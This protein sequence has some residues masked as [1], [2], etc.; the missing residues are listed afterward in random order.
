MSKETLFPLIISNT[1]MSL[2][3]QC[4]LRWF[5][6]RCQSL[7]KPGLKNI[8]LDAGAAFAKG[9]EVTREAF[10]QDKLT[11]AESIDQG[12]HKVLEVMYE[13]GNVNDDL[14]SPERMAL[15]L[16][17][18]FKYFP[19]ES[20]DVVPAEL[21]DGT[22]AIEHKM[23]AELPILHPELG[24]P[25]IFKGKL[26][27]LATNMGR[28]YIVDEKTTKAITS[29]TGELLATSG[30]FIG[31]AWLCRQLGIS[32]AGAKI[33]KVAI[34]K[35]AIKFQEFEVPITDFMIDRWEK[36]TIRKVTDMVGNYK[37]FMTLP[38]NLEEYF[39]ADYS[40]GC[41]A[42]FQPCPY[43]AGCTTRYGEGFIDT[44]FEQLI[45]DSESRKEIPLVEFKKLVGL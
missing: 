14:K 40:N 38:H 4:Q 17:E 7:R 25:I 5:R 45:W 34:Q 15:A 18:Y 26:D 10:Y 31:Y 24:V 27:M 3:S 37:A 44:E 28:T 20:D 8:N 13:S 16:V 39:V 21:E 9:M 43:T 11:P 30:Q 41:T 23:T 33:R 19:L 6:E 22:S 42:Y 12:Y 1:D 36:A 32:V 2:W 35:T 29:N